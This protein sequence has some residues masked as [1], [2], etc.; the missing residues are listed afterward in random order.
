MNR[1]FQ[2]WL[3]LITAATV[4]IPVCWGIAYGHRLP[5]H[6]NHQWNSTFHRISYMEPSTDKQS[7]EAPKEANLWHRVKTFALRLGINKEVIILWA[8][9]LLGAPVLVVSIIIAMLLRPR[10]RPK[11]TSSSCKKPPPQQPL[12]TAP[13]TDIPTKQPPPPR[14]KP[15]RPAAKMSDHQQVLRFF[16]Q[17]YKTQLNADAEAPAQIVRTATRPTCPDETYEMRILDKKDWAIRRM[18]IGLLGQGGGSRSKCFYVIYDSHMV[19]KIPPTPM[20]KFS[21]YKHQVAAEGNIVA[22]LAPR[23]CIVPRI[24]VILKAIHTFPDADQLSEEQ[25]E[26]RYM[27]LVET[28]RELHE[29]LKIGDSFAFF[30][31]LARHFFLSTT[32]EEIHSGYGRIADEIDKHP[33]LLWD[34]HAFVSRY[35]EDSGGVCLALQDAYYRCE[36]QLRQLTATADVS[37][38]IT[39]YH[40]KQWFLSH[41]IGEPVKHETHDLPSDLITKANALLEEVVTANRH[42]VSVYRQHLRDYIRRTR[43][44]RYRRQ[45]EGLATNILD[46]L[47]WIGKRGLALRDLKPENLFVAGNPDEY[48]QFLNDPEKFSL[49]L[50][51]VETAVAIDAEDPVLIPQPQLAGTPLYAT[52]THLMSNLLLLEVFEDL[53]DILHMQDW[54]ATIGMLFKLITGEP[55][56]ATTAHTFPELLSRLKVLDPTGADMQEDVADIH[57]VFWNSAVAEFQANMADHASAL[58]DVE[59][60]VPRSLAEELLPGLKSD[61]KENQKAVT[62][63]VGNQSFFKSGDRRRYLKDASSGKINQMKSKLNQEAESRSGPPQDQVL[64]YFELLEKLKAR[65][66]IKQHALAALSGHTT[67]ITA[68]QLLEAMFQRVL[69]T[70]YPAHWPPIAPRLYGSSSFLATDIT[71]YQATM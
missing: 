37:K 49:G 15:F 36:E 28:N 25:L 48:P 44:S 32:M 69:T 38:S 46:L 23:L 66:E 18:S 31:D 20:T 71:T 24:S 9:W 19:I 10:R 68:D 62:K 56:F 59:I 12:C 1:F 54:H 60:T 41:M 52:P 30:M 67:T 65:L 8:K 43:F 11:P 34:Q 61:I 5:L 55:L 50:I 64:L 63:A 6:I 39:T 40:F 58:A 17:L 27:Q 13:K 53:A 51:D 35:G 26:N 45:V 22:R 47:A 14:R 16:L 42:Q 2:R 29:Y 7:P 3:C 33:E 70:M 21:D 57:A 4:L